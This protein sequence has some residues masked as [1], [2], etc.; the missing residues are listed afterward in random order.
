MLTN[1]Q[2]P[3]LARRSPLVGREIA[4]RDILL[5][6]EMAEAIVQPRAIYLRGDFDPY[7]S[8][9]IEKDQQRLHPHPWESF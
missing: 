6:E 8:S 4:P 2:N 1:A 5:T 3:K 7:R 9:H